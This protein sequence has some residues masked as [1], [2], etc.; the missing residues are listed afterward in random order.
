MRAVGHKLEVFGLGPSIPSYQHTLRQ[1]NG[2]CNRWPRTIRS[3]RNTATNT[4][5]SCHPFLGRLIFVCSAY[6][7]SSGFLP[8]AASLFAVVASNTPPAFSDTLSLLGSISKADQRGP[9]CS[10]RSLY[11]TLL[12]LA[13]PRVPG[14]APTLFDTPGI[15]PCTA[16]GGC[17]R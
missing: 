16:P 11:R 14:S 17:R 15:G 6:R 9:S 13:L 5:A 4:I 12:C 1:C 10:S 7:F 2:H 8:S 3:I